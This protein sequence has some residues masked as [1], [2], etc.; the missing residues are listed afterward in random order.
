MADGASLLFLRPQTPD[1]RS[2]QPAAEACL[3]FRNWFWGAFRSDWHCHLEARAVLVAG[4]V[5]GRLPFGTDVAFPGYVGDVG[6]RVRTFSDGGASWL[7][8]FRVHVDGME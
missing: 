6:V 1:Q 8:Q 3:H 5:D 4:V 2:L 7:E